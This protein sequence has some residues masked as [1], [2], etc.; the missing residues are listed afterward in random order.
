MRFLRKRLY[1]CVSKMVLMKKKRV[2][3]TDIAKELGVTPSTVSRALGGSNRVSNDTRERVLAT[4]KNMGYNPNVLASSLRRG[5]SDTIGMIVPRINRHFFSHVIS[6]VEAILNPRGFNLLVSQSHEKLDHEQRAIQSLLSNRVGGI[7]I[8]H[9]VETNRFKHLENVL[10]EDVPLVQFDRVSEEVGGPRIVNDNFLGALRTM[11]H[12]IKNGCNRIVHFAGSLH[13]NVYKERLE[14]YK[15]AL[16][17]AGIDFDP[18]LV[19]ENCI[20]METGACAIENILKEFEV[21]AVFSSSDYSAL[22][23]LKRLKQMNI[24]VPGK[25]K[26]TGFANEPF[27]ELVDPSLTSVEQNGFEMGSRLA[28]VMIDCIEGTNIGVEEISIPVRLIVRESS[29]PLEASGIFY[30]AGVAGG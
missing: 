8:S 19:V 7:I 18:A 22:G 13:V 23:A 27:A 16:K 17:Q 9:S 15:F 29:V 4:A 30:S 28:E 12:L 25:I 6:G 10:L 24:N 1:F 2:T 26:V 21:D 14:G 20:T 5:K 3:I 11:Q